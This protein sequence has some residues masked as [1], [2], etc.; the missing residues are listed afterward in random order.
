MANG[1]SC[2]QQRKD[3]P[4]RRA[5]RSSN[6]SRRRLVWFPVPVLGHAVVGW[7]TAEITPPSPAESRSLFL[8]AMLIASYFPDLVGQAAAGAGIER[9]RLMSHSVVLGAAAAPLLGMATA[10]ILG[11]FSRATFLIALSILLHDVLDALQ[12]TDRVPFYPL[13][14]VGLQFPIVIPSGLLGE[15]GLVGALAGLVVGVHRRWSRTRLQRNHRPLGVR[16]LVTLVVLSATAVVTH[17]LG[18]LREAQATAAFVA[19]EQG[20]YREALAGLDGA[21]RWP[22]PAKPGRTDYLRGEAHRGLGDRVSAERWYLS[23]LRKDPSY[24]WALAD[25]VSL[26]ASGSEPL[27]QRR[28]RVRPYFDRLRRYPEPYARKVLQMTADRL[29]LRL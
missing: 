9:A 22:A 20:R 24:M 21:D 3:A 2:S 8:P 18:M 17:R 16:G 4:R 10:R 26:Y 12:A 29:D 27:D 15:L 19:I 5:E 23:S 25:L 14:D 28:E 6:P 7:A 13:S 1:P 11:G